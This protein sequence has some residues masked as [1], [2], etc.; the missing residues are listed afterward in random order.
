MVKNKHY[1]ERQTLSHNHVYKS[2]PVSHLPV[3]NSR[4]HQLSYL[5]YRGKI[6]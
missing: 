5:C 1:G 6:I 2:N 4:K 3:E